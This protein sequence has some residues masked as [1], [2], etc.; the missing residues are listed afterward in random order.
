MIRVEAMTAVPGCC[1]MCQRSDRRAVDTQRDIG[2][3]RLYVCDVCI[4]DLVIAAGFRIEDADCVADLERREGAIHAA[5]EALN[6]REAQLA[7]LE[8][9]H[10]ELLHA[11]KFL[12]E[13]GA[14]IRSGKIAL[15]KAPGR[16]RTVEL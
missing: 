10:T 9:E 3:W 4:A 5:T 14:T 2:G 13:K 16:K 11:V 12:F 1:A 8:G 15:R 6:E 7:D